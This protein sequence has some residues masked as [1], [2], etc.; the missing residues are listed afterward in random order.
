MKKE[1]VSPVCKKIGLTFKSRRI[2]MNEMIKSEKKYGVKNDEN[3]NK[4]K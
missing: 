2:K 3:E 1:F 4:K